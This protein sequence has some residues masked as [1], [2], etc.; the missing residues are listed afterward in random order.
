MTRCDQAQHRN[1]QDGARR[2][3]RRD[4]R[5]PGGWSATADVIGQLPPTPRAVSSTRTTVDTANVPCAT[6]TT[7]GKLPSGGVASA[8]WAAQAGSAAAPLG[9]SAGTAATASAV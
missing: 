3:R 5:G 6:T 4:R 2:E 9:T 1:W 7:S 8:T